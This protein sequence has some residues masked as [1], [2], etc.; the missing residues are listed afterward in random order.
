MHRDDRGDRVI[1]DPKKLV[2][3]DVEGMPFTFPVDLDS[4][5]MGVLVGAE[6]ALPELPD[7]GEIRTILDIGGNVGAYALYCRKRWPKAE[8]IAYEPHPECAALYRKNA[9][10]ATVIEAAVTA[11]PRARD[12][13]GGGTI[14]LHEGRDWGM[15]TI[16]GDMYKDPGPTITVPT[17]HPWDLPPCDVLKLDAE[18][19]ELQVLAQYR[20]LEGVHVCVYEWHKEIFREPCQKILA[21]AGLRIFHA[22]QRLVCIGIEHWIRSKAVF[23]H[24]A[25]KYVLP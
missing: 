8:I 7:M 2:T 5:V 23:D 16:F 24:Q 21:D 4:C 25:R 22:N 10:W 12:A 13:K 1:T 15:N 20:H 6:Y 3:V 18:G 14:L 11:E 19:V 9:P 17:V